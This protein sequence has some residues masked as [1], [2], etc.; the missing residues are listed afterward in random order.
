LKASYNL[1]RLL[2]KPAA[3]A[4]LVYVGALVLLGVALTLTISDPEAMATYG[5]LSALPWIAVLPDVGHAYFAFG[6]NALTIY[7]AVALLTGHARSPRLPK[8]LFLRQA[9]D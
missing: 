9:V 7:L 5:W 2:S 1:K 3:V 6:I 8:S 4:V